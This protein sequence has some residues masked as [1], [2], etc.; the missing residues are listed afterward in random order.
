MTDKPIEETRNNT[1]N[2][3][4]SQEFLKIAQWL[5]K[6]RFRKKIFGGVC[7]QDVWKKIGEL[8]AMYEEALR[9]E[10]IRYDA[11]IEHYR[12]SLTSDSHEEIAV[13]ED[14]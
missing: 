7:E 3:E 5:K 13:E 2:E 4:L 14:Y 8:N 1:E 9:A 11:L 10:R 6:L 12:K